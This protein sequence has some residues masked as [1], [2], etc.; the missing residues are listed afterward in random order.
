MLYNR[1]YTE[2]SH[3]VRVLVLLVI[4]VAT[5]TVDKQKRHVTTD[6]GRSSSDYWSLEGLHC[7]RVYTP[8]ERRHMV[9]THFSVWIFWPNVVLPSICPLAFVLMNWEVEQGIA[10]WCQ[11]PESE[12]HY[13]V[14]S[15]L[16]IPKFLS[17]FHEY[18]SKR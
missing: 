13:R 12:K 9:G 14:H 17:I 7:W 4:S 2:V 1:Y 5:W 11:I 15:V 6:T 18:Y 3:N 16:K 10:A 8:G